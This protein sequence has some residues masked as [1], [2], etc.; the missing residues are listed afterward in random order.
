VLRPVVGT[1]RRGE[2][3]GVDDRSDV[4]TFEPSGRIT[5]TPADGGHILHLTGDIDA[6]VVEK[7]SSDHDP[8]GLRILAV[9]VGDLRY[10]DSSGL[11][12]LV[13]WAQDARRDGRPAEIRRATQRF[14]RILEVA[15]LTALFVVH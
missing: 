2:S 15:G 8:D 12:F 9:D 3:G 5:V 14:G 4:Q 10:I 6:P 1:A 11:T 7:L 13:R